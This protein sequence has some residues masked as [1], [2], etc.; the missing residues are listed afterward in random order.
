[1]EHGNDS[2]LDHLIQVQSD[3]KKFQA[4]WRKVHWSDLQWF[5]HKTFPFKNLYTHKR[6]KKTHKGGLQRHL[7]TFGSL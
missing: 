7:R 3:M 6:E 1:M 5:Q 4:H 2:E